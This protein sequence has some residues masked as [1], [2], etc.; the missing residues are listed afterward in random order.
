MGVVEFNA[1]VNVTASQG[2]GTPESWE[3]EDM[4]WWQEAH[5]RR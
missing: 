1:W 5:E 4:G 3:G 2:R